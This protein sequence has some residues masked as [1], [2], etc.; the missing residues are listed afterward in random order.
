MAIPLGKA[1]VS[2]TMRLSPSGV[3]TAMSPLFEPRSKFMPSAPII[4]KLIPFTY[5]A[6]DGCTATSF[7]P[8]SERSDRSA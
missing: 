7:H 1:M 4:A 3:T 8:W 5:A 2:A 6:P